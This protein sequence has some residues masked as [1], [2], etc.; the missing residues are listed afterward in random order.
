MVYLVWYR[1]NVFHD[2]SLWGV[3]GDKDKADEAVDLILKG[4]Y[5]YEAWVNTEEVQ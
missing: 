4:G 5:G 2:A 1:T 3:Y